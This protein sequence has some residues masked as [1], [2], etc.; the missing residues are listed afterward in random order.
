[1]PALLQSYGSYLFLGVLG[2]V[3]GSF[4]TVL[5]DRLPKCLPWI[6]GRSQCRSCDQ[7]LSVLDLVPIL[8]YFGLKGKCR[9]C[10]VTIPKWI[11]VVEVGIS[12]LYCGLFYVLGWSGDLLIMGAFFT[13][14][15]VIFW[16]DIFHEIIPNELILFLTVLGG[17]LTFLSGHWVYS[18]G[19]AAGLYLGY[20]LIGLLGYLYYKRPV[21][22]GGDYKLLA[23]IGL[24]FGWEVGLMSLY[25]AFALGGIFATYKLLFGQ[26]KLQDTLPFAPMLIAGTI[27]ALVW[28]NFILSLIL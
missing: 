1:M 20:G 19:S 16:T 4:C 25:I 24:F 14:M 9:Y 22:G 13:V 28:G 21:I 5:I 7:Q 3:I 23:M 2:A 15:M 17:I 6:K 12:I 8:S 27:I 11:P 26:K 10:G 18:F